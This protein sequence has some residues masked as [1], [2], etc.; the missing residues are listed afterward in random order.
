V[1]YEAVEP[2]VEL[3]SSAPPAR[4]GKLVSIDPEKGFKPESSP[5]LGYVFKRA[6]QEFAYTSD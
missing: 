4:S 6:R 3:V 1:G 5:M 2:K